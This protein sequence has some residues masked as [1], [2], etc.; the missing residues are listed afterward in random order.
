M[1]F[2]GKNGQQIGENIETIM[3]DSGRTDSPP[4]PAGVAG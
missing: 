1:L 3:V 4:K 2:L